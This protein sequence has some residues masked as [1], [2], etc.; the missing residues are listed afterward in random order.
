MA[1]PSTN[2]S[3]HIENYFGVNGV[4]GP[5]VENTYYKNSVNLVFLTDD[6]ELTCKAAFIVYFK[7]VSQCVGVP[8]CFVKHH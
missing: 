3:G 1:L 6:I 4:H 2:V 7:K 8:S 5:Q